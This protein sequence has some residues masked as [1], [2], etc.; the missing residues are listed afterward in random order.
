M[1]ALTV[2]MMIAPAAAGCWPGPEVGAEHKQM[3]LPDGGV[4]MGFNE[5]LSTVLVPTCATSF[6][7]KPDPPPAAP[8]SLEADKAYGELVG[9]DSSQDPKLKR[10][11][12]G[13]P[14][15]SYVLIKLHADLAT[16]HGTTR[17]PLNKPPL[18]DAT[19]SQ[20]EQWILRGAPN[21]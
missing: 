8:M 9:V 1:R 19:L 13:D 15:N 7:H 20:I 3:L 16:A 6:C 2:V 21:D 11:A 4:Q 12:P 18:D 5:L 17:M 14:M 10:V